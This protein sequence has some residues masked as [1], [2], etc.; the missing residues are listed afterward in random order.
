MK[1]NI[2]NLRETENDL[3]F[4]FSKEDLD[5]ENINFNSGIIV[6]TKVIKTGSQVDIK[7]KL[8][9]KYEYE[10]DRCLEMMEGKID[11]DFELIYK[12]DLRNSESD[13][14]TDDDIKF[15][16]PNTQT[17]NIKEDIRDFVLISIPMKNAPDEIDG[18]C[19]GCNKSNEEILISNKEKEINPV[20]DKLLKN[21]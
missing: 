15:I 6:N 14:D 16:P 11:N 4:K 9:G 20:W 7:V 12:L 1:I 21:K 19:S 17:I 2:H 10:C 18:I 13:F 3:E 5:I 8:Q